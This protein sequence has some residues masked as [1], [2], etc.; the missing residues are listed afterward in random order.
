[1]SHAMAGAAPH[2][3]NR[4]RLLLAA[5]LAAVVAPNAAA[6][7]RRPPAFVLPELWGVAA[8]GSFRSTTFT[9]LHRAGINTVVIDTRGLRD[10]QLQ[11]LTRAAGQARLRVVQPTVFPPKSVVD[12][13]TVCNAFRSA[14]PGSVCALW[15]SS[16]SFAVTL[17][18]SG[19]ADLVVVRLS[20]PG[21]LRTFARS[22]S[23]G[24][25]LAVVPLEAHF[26]ATV[27]RNAIRAAS[28]NATLDIAFEPRRARQKTVSGYLR[29]LDKLGATSPDRTAPTNPTG[30]TIAQRTQTT[31]GLSWN[32]PYD[33]RGV[34]GYY[35]YVDGALLGSTPSTVY[36]DSNLHCGTSHVLTVEAFDAA[37]N[38]STKSSL[39]AETSPCVL[40]PLIDVLPPSAPGN[41][42]MSGRTT[43]TISL[44]WNPS[45]DDLGVAGYGLHRN[46]VL[47]GSTQS[48]SFTFSG[49][50]C[51]TYY[52]LAVDAFDLTGGR[53]PKAS[54]RWQTLACS[55]P[56]HL[57]PH[58]PP[59]PPPPPHPHP[60]P[61]PAT[62][63]TAGL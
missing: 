23:G 8:N 11:R 7:D 36:T 4:L 35:F 40:S 59:P 24:R 12:A 33:K 51:G 53:S 5:I 9:W 39:G 31:L 46:N 48:T 25:I 6:A 2:P 63:L 1:M 60:P 49:L 41:L 28:S 44:T 14:H 38:R 30:L 54:T 17:G 32:T 18:K 22:S 3:S 10:R 19:A 15:E 16:A 61:T 56:P 47:V 62:S 58:H 52:E 21:A 27:W 26:R 43:S 13:R 37:G 50:T 34:A 42:Q 29:L 55:P 57:H 45:V 20:G